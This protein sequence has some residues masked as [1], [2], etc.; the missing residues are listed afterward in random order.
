MSRKYQVK[1]QPGAYP[2]PHELFAAQKVADHFQTNVLFLKEMTSSTPDLRIKNQ[3]WELKS[4]IGKGKE[5]MKKSIRSSRKQSNRLVIDLSRCP[6]IDTKCISRL[7]NYFFRYGS[8]T[9]VRE[10]LVIK[11]DGGIIKIR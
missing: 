8:R 3:T 2:R 11:K 4:P 1:I 9:H 7:K 10:L 6:V 5:T